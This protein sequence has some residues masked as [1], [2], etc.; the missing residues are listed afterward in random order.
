MVL[1]ALI[2]I[3]AG[4][5]SG[6]GSALLTNWMQRSSLREARSEER[7]AI[8]YV[9]VAVNLVRR[10]RI[11]YM[12]AH[13][14]ERPG[15]WVNTDLDWEEPLQVLANLSV[16]GSEAVQKHYKLV[17]ASFSNFAIA[18]RSSP[19]GARTPDDLVVRLQALWVATDGEMTKLLTLMNT[20]L[21]H[22]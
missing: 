6:I 20:E 2:G 17:D 8:A 19:P 4:L 5:L 7:R 1:D 3:V 22:S 13:P 15:G 21:H 10:Q 18:S 14:T 11:C 12:L 9:N 16:F